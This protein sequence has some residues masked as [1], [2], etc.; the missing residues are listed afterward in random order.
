[1]GTDYPC[2][3]RKS[4]GMYWLCEVHEDKLLSMIDPPIVPRDAI[5]PK[6]RKDDRTVGQILEHM[7]S[8]VGKPTPEERQRARQ[9][10]RS[11]MQILDD[12]G[13]KLD[14]AM[15]QELALMQAH[16]EAIKG[17]IHTDKDAAADYIKKKF[18]H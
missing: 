2:G 7:Q 15:N 1:M 18:K 9:D 5:K 17:P 14:Q 11:A 4:A 13:H 16:F 12:M 8:I 3:C 10:P 6:P